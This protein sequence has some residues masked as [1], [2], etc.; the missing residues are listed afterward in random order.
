MEFFEKMK[1]TIN[2]FSKSS[3]DVAKE[4]ID[5]VS[6]KA[7]EYSIIT[8][9]KMEIKSIEHKIDEVMTD[10]GTEYYKLYSTNE[11]KNLKK[12]LTTPLEKIESLK[13]N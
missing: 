13:Q 6:K 4:S 12:D 8:N 2:K 3:A 9:L 1:E 5:R 7:T 11:L 10:L